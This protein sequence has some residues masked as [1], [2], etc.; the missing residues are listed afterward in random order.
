MLSSAIRIDMTI[1]DN[2]KR[3]SQEGRLATALATAGASHPSGLVSFH[4]VAFYER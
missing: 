2:G 4:F 1:D 3:T